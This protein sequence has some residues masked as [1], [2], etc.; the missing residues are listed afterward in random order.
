MPW[1]LFS[2]DEI[3]FIEDEFGK[4]RTV[5]VGSAEKR[6]AIGAPQVVSYPTVKSLAKGLKKI[7]QDGSDL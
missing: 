4:A 3:N 2:G 1:E 5:S 7:I 6:D